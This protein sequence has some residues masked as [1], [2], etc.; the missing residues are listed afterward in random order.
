[1]TFSNIGETY[2]PVLTRVQRRNAAQLADGARTVAQK[3]LFMTTPQS[4]ESS[5]GCCTCIANGSGIPKL[6][7]R[8]AIQYG[9]ELARGRIEH[10]H[11][12]VMC[13]DRRFVIGVPCDQLDA[14]R[15]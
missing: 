7:N 10:H 11:R 14:Q 6:G 2:S 1:M 3:R 13:R 9:L 15:L 5:W 8:L 4:D 12:G